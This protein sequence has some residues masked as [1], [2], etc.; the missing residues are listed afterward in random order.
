MVMSAATF[1]TGVS[2]LIRVGRGL[3]NSY[4]EHLRN[5]DFQLLL[6]PGC[7]PARDTRELLVAA[8][9]HLEVRHGGLLSPGQAFHGIFRET[10]S[11]RPVINEDA[12][13]LINQAIDFYLESLAGPDA[14]G[15]IVIADEPVVISRS[16]VLLHKEWLD[17]DQ[18]SRWARLG[19]EIAGVAL[20]VIS[21]QPD[22][23][24]LNRRATEIIGAL[25]TNLN[26]LVDNDEVSGSGDQSPGERMVRQFVQASLET[27][28]ERPEIFVSE[29]RWRPIVSGIVVPLKEHVAANPGF[30][31]MA[32]ER[33]RQVF[34]GPLAH[35]MLTAINANA[36]AFL[37]SRFGSA[38][39][40]GA[41]TRSVL[42]AITSSDQTEFDLKDV[43]SDEAAVFVYEAALGVARDRPEL[44]LKSAGLEA[45][46][47]RQF[48]RRIAGALHDAPRPYSL[49]AGLAPQIAAISFEVAGEYA[50]TRV[51]LFDD[52]S[53]WATAKT[54]VAD[55]LIGQIVDGFKSVVG[56]GTAQNPFERLF[57]R[58]QAVDVLRIIATH[59][60]RTPAMAVGD[61]ANAE[62][63]NI[64]VG[65]AQ[66]LAD[67][68]AGLLDGDD[69][70]AV[71][72]RMMELA[73]LNPGALFSINET[74]RPE[75]QVAVALIRGV[76]ARAADNMAAGRAPGAILFG[77]T[78]REALMATLAAGTSNLL[79]LIDADAGH[80]EV[81]RLAG[82]VGALEGFIQHLLDLAGGEAPDFR[83]S[84]SEWLY[85]YRY[86]VAHVI[87]EGPNAFSLEA[88]AA[89]D[90]EI[91]PALI[92]NAR[93]LE[94][95]QGLGAEPNEE[96]DVG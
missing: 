34:R 53:A 24:G 47:Q 13:D 93:I 84:A 9:D 51:R 83:M 16:V 95:L 22:V 60:A 27:V 49:S 4:H 94:V 3:R 96:R 44:F 54:D 28:A 75:S 7:P 50:S 18:P 15:A 32:Q 39:V 11:G 20:D 57:H 46:A 67:D 89:D 72:A 77:E 59:V 55:H 65:V 12:G 35:S 73:A 76:L 88:L 63:R 25:A 56:A 43:F 23:L 80:E 64:A 2:G 58:E 8:L 62:V 30:E 91:P 90:G 41:V 6:P 85:V 74:A 78:L 14:T 69:W 21:V 48:L 26:A 66:M 92:T 5:R 86:F 31:F 40:L 70:R 52:D 33:L 87:A 61:G 68:S 79:T 42:G 81:D 82:H 10:S 17:P 29:E 38:E 1:L 19:V 71:V 45:D 37:T 36:D